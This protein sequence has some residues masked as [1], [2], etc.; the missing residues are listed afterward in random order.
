MH[1][2]LEVNDIDLPIDHLQQAILILG[3]VR[4]SSIIEQKAILKHAIPP[5]L[6][7]LPDDSLENRRS[8]SYR[9]ILSYIDIVGELD[10]G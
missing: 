10:V 5:N 7:V 2:F 6:N 9:R 1:L 3:I 8:R 4:H